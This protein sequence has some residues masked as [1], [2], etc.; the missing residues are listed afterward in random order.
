MRFFWGFLWEEEKVESVKMNSN[1]V[2]AWRNFPDI[3]EALF[4]EFPG[5][6]LSGT[7]SLFGISWPGNFFWVKFAENQQERKDYEGNDCG[8]IIDNR[9]SDP[10]FRIIL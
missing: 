9:F 4:L 7:R 5:K 1:D 8:K 3:F 6:L 10:F 2:S